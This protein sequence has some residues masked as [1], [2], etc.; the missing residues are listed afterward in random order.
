MQKDI[1]TD[2]TKIFLCGLSR[3]GKNSVT[4]A[5]TQLGFGPSIRFP[6]SYDSISKYQICSDLSVIFWMDRLLMEYP[7]S[8][9]ILTLRDTEDWLRDCQSFFNRDLNHFP[10]ELTEQMLYYRE[11]IYGSRV[12]EEALWRD[13]YN[14]HKDHVLSLIPHSQILTIDLG[15]SYVEAWSCIQN[16]LGVSIDYSDRDFPHLNALNKWEP[17]HGQ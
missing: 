16:F 1:L 12:Y 14:R 2:K 13:T 8:Y 11:Q 17:F 7:S 10:A 15:D 6:M 4:C 9:W 5:L 3:T